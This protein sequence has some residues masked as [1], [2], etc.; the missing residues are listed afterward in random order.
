MSLF[1]SFLQNLNS[2]LDG[3]CENYV[4]QFELDIS[5]VF[6]LFM[7]RY[8]SRSISKRDQIV[9]KCISKQNP[10]LEQVRCSKN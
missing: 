1:Q 4:Y 8:S 3:N 10:S 5:L 9:I 2:L 7:L 6:G